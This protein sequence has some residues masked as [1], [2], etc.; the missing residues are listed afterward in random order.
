MRGGEKDAMEPRDAQ[1]AGGEW[2]E[3]KGKKK[4]KTRR[5]HGDA[6]IPGNKKQK[7]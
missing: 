4:R 1:S 5:R 2:Q 6:E 3:G 7:I